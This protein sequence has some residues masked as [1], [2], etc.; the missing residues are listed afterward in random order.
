MNG[1][2]IGSTI[3]DAV[4]KRH[5]IPM[6]TEPV[7]T[8]HFILFSPVISRRIAVPVH[9]R[10]SER[11]LKYL[12]FV[13]RLPSSIGALSDR[14]ALS[15]ILRERATLASRQHYH[16]GDMRKAPSRR[17]TSPLSIA[18]SMMCLASAAYSAGS[19]SRGGNG[20]C[21]P[22]DFLMSSGNPASSGVSNRPG[23][24][25][26]TR[27]PDRARSRAIGSVIPTIPPSDA[28]YA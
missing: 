14:Y 3:T 11:S 27:M 8:L 17:I 13:N 1:A 10:D 25:V 21:A 7:A 16:F 9:I 6:Q 18:F 4:A 24:M 19:P 2:P 26:T 23:A 22:S 5:S 20:I 15:R 12:L 28:D